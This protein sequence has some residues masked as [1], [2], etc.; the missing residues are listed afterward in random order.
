MKKK[1]IS[2]MIVATILAISIIPAAVYA[3]GKTEYN[4][5]YLHT[6]GNQ[7]L[8]S[9]GNRVKLTGIA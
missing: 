5:D 2:K 3:S 4:D 9:D 8:D 7:I 6:D 1:I